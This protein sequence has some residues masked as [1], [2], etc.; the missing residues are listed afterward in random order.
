M[1]TRISVA[2]LAAV[3]A[4]LLF[5]APAHAQR[6]RVFVASY[7]SDSNPCTFGSPC[8][9]FQQAIDVVAQG[10][11]VTAI[12]SA[13]F[14]TIT[15]SHAVTITSPNG[16]EAGI[17]APES[18]SAAVTISA[19]SS[20]AVILNGLTLDGDNVASTTGIN[21]TAGGSLS[22][23][24]S[25]IRKFSSYGIQ[26]SSSGSSA[27]LMSNSQVSNNLNGISISAYNANTAIESI[28]DRVVIEKNGN[29]GL[30]ANTSAGAINLTLGESICGGNGNT[31]FDAISD[32]GTVNA[33]I[34]NSTVANNT[35]EGVVAD[36]AGV[37]FWLTRTTITENG[38]GWLAPDGGTVTSYGDNSIDGNT[39]GN[40]AP[41]TT[42]YK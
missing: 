33:F 28:L 5:A 14:G 9:T 31:G 3:F 10:G 15:I 23:Q 21:F 39:S 41:P 32:G 2:L 16:V 7:G 18:G 42:P 19:G 27:L 25:V 11:E 4:C 35:Y 12:D 26:F 38:N 34:R 36:G 20:D 1:L 13:G 29:Y 17:A 24:N 30:Y 22:I 6:D 8:K 40:T 37:Q